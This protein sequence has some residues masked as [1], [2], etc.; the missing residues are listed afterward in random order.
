M[1]RRSTA[2]YLAV[3]SFGALAILVMLT[4]GSESVKSFSYLL[5]DAVAAA[6]L[7]VGARIHKPAKPAAWHL[8][9]LGLGLFV[10]SDAT[11]EFM[12]VVLHKPVQNGSAIDLTYLAGYI[13]I[14][15]GLSMM[16]KA[17]RP[18][19]DRSSLIDSVIVGVACGLASWQ[20]VLVPA[21]GYAG[22]GFLNIVSIC[23][24]PS[25]DIVLLAFTARLVFVGGKRSP[26]FLSLMAGFSI[27]FVTDVIYS[28]QSIDGTYMP[29]QWLDA[30]V[31]L[32]QFA[33][34]TAALHPSMR[35]LTEPATGEQAVLSRGR[36][37]LLGLALIVA[38]S[39]G[40]TRQISDGEAKGWVVVGVSILLTSLVLGRVFGL[41][42][43]TERARQSVRDNATR[44]EG[45]VRHNSDLMV[46]ISLDGRVT[47]VAEAAHR[48]LDRPMSDFL[49][50]PIKSMVHPDD[51]KQC[52][53]SAADLVHNHDSVA[54]AAFRV[55]HSSG[56][57]LFFEGHMTLME[58]PTRPPTI[59]INA[60]DATDRR[61]SIDALNE[62]AAQQAA[63]AAVGELALSGM[64]LRLLVQHAVEVIATTLNVETCFT[65]YVDG[66]GS[67]ANTDVK[68]L[69]HFIG[70]GTGHATALESSHFRDNDMGELLT[71]CLQNGE[72][73]IHSE[74]GVDEQYL[75]PVFLRN[76]G[77]A[78]MIAIRSEGG[79]MVTV[80]QDPTPFSSDNFN[81][82]LS[83]TN[84]IALAGKRRQAESEVFH[85]SVHDA[86]TGL[87]NR[88]LFLERLNETLSVSHARFERVGVMFIDLDRFKLVNDSL[89]HEAGDRLLIE[90]SK[91]VRR[92]IRANDVLARMSGDEFTV[93]CP[94]ITSI[95][96]VLGVG[97][98]ILQEL[99]EPFTIG[100]TTVTTTVS[101]GVT[102]SDDTGA[103]ADDFIREADLAMYQSKQRG[104]NRIEVFNSLMTE[105]ARHRLELENDL[106]HAVAHGEFVVH[107]QPVVHLKMSARRVGAEALVRWI[108]PTRGMI[109]PLDFIPLAEEIGLINDIGLFVL[110]DACHHLA[111]WAPIAGYGAPVVSV[112][113]SARQLVNPNLVNQVADVLAETGVAASSLCLEV[114]ES[115]LMDDVES[116]TAALSAL[117]NLGL[118]MAIDD[119][120]TGYSSLAALKRLPVDI[121]KIDKS[122]VDGLGTNPDDSAIVKAIIGL[123]HT[124]GLTALAEGVETAGQYA[125]LVNLGCD[126][127]QGFYF[128]RPGPV[129]ELWNRTANVT[130]SR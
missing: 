10:L 26:A 94:G 29:H 63:V 38:P 2:L 53:K 65:T 80:R 27:F 5:A 4:N 48:I 96:E 126:A 43:I 121:L 31:L 92:S 86:L 33:I 50:K 71:R 52:L 100:S 62:R 112:N 105:G 25:L 116:A 110:R 61:R 66:V 46:E 3:M 20:F 45:L 7:V 58:Q 64:E 59:I 15:I 6:S 124:M 101:I 72:S 122:F 17:R 120:G 73:L 123:A 75:L 67:R 51:Y 12:D 78:S 36:V 128:G 90:L 88:A 39:I 74:I 19:R 14:A 98:R 68:G 99:T 49:D 41:V 11:W 30:S 8:I 89:G 69:L 117:R 40:A 54:P 113:L 93:M 13:P 106:R 119:F 32:A 115:I 77:V 103:D 22:S 83:I 21:K 84:A 111:T 104:R 35:T 70:P 37:L 16:A 18:E 82:I 102:I 87:P 129:E 44:F 130:P 57:W 24:F 76:L 118:R 97:E 125:E 34:G 85:R 55:R 60:H 127:A 109:P 23:G 79:T 91:R 56:E 9:G 81:F 42:G 28:L 114:T 1:I 95:D 47:F 108:H 107:Y